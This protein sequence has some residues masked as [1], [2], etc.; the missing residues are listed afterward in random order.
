MCWLFLRNFFLLPFKFIKKN[1]Q[2]L[3]QVNTTFFL[4]VCLV[5]SDKQ[6]SQLLHNS[7]PDANKKPFY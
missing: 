4:F 1:K 2:I 3:F 6:K 5:R 7:K